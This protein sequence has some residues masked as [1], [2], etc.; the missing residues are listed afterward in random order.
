MDANFHLML[1]DNS[2]NIGAPLT[3]EEFGRSINGNDGSWMKP[4]LVK[5]LSQRRNSRFPHS[6]WS[7]VLE[8][9]KEKLLLSLSIYHS[10][11]D[12]DL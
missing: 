12:V 10:A 8:I 3:S 6:K 1:V 11:F 9:Y 7:K 2:E 4:V 5:S